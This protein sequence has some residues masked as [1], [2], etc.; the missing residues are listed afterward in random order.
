MKIQLSTYRGQFEWVKSIILR[1]ID[2][3][4]ISE[5]VS[6][7]SSSVPIPVI[8]LF[9]YAKEILGDSPEIQRCIDSAMKFYKYHSVEE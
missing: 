7:I 5:I 8:V 4:S 1:D 6:S 9:H 3:K 2:K